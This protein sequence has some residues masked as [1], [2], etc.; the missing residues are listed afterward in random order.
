[1]D[2]QPSWSDQDFTLGF[3]RLAFNACDPGGVLVSRRWQE[4]GDKTLTDHVEN[5]S[6]VVIKRTRRDAGGDNRKVIAHFR[7]VKDALVRLD[8]TVIECFSSKRVLDLAQ[9]RFYSR[10]IILGQSA[11]I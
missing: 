3:E 6:L 5:R 9:C 10:N 11:R 7:V 1:I 8:P 2:L 4:T